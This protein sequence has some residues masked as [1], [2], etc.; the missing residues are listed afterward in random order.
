MQKADFKLGLTYTVTY[1]LRSF[2]YFALN[3]QN[4]VPTTLEI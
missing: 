3:I 1:G 4:I 2:G